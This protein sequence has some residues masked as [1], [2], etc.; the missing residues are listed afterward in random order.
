MKISKL[1]NI[2]HMMKLKIGDI[3]PIYDMGS[4]VGGSK[5][6]G[7]LEQKNG[8]EMV[9][10]VKYKGGKGEVFSRVS[11]EDIEEGGAVLEGMYHLFSEHGGKGVKI[12]HFYENDPA[13]KKYGG[14]FK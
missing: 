10:L 7:M 14:V 13:I 2:E 12:K 3:I 9:L 1:E 5:C 11:L 8:K 4:N 6:H